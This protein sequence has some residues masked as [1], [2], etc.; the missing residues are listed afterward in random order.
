MAYRGNNISE[1]EKNKLRL[2]PE[3]LANSYYYFRELSGKMI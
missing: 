2:A 1:D 3:W